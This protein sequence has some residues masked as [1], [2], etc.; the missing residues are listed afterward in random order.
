MSRGGRIIQTTEPSTTANLSGM[1]D[2][3]EILGYINQTKWPR[4]PEAP[5]NL[6]AT[7]GD[8]Q[9]SL[10]WTAPATTHGTI[11][12]YLV[13]YTPSGG[14]ATYVLTGS[15]STSYTLTGLT[16]GT[17]YSVRVAA[18][19]AAGTGEYSQAATPTG[20]ALTTT[21]EGFTGAGTSSDKLRAIDTTRYRI[22]PRIR[23]VAQTAGLFKMSWSKAYSNDVEKAF[24]AGVLFIDGAQNLINGSTSTTVTAGQEVVIRINLD[25]WEELNRFMDF[26]DLQFWID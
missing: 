14:S 13:E 12:N 8:V 7:A 9:L 10:S 22:Q 25:N 24:I 16:N 2:L 21:A 23:L 17:E 15:T 1:W 26:D 3:N 20:A 5:T 6:T 11:T 19:N 18:V 4:G